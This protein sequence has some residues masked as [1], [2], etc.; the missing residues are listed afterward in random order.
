MEYSSEIAPPRNSLPFME[1][2]ILLP[3]TQT[4]KPNVVVELTLLRIREVP[5]TNLGPEIGYPDRGTSL[6][7]SV[8]P[9]KFWDSSLKVDHDR[10]LSDSSFTYHPLLDAT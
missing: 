7:A 6:F 10:F 1:H 5:G 2:E 8:S 4:P 3:C 9:S